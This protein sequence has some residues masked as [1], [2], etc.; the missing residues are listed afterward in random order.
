MT[1]QDLL[2]RPLLRGV[3]LSS[4]EEA[5]PSSKGRQT[6]RTDVREEWGPSIRGTPSNLLPSQ[7]PQTSEGASKIQAQV[8]PGVRSF[9]IPANP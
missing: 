6:Q 2:V 9:L 4:R 7:G 8:Q 3:G 1:Q 5:R